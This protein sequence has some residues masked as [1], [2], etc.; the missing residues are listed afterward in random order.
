[1]ASHDNKYTHNFFQFKIMIVLSYI[2]FCKIYRRLPWKAWKRA[3]IKCF[4]RQNFQGVWFLIFVAWLFEICAIHDGL[5][6]SLQCFPVSLSSFLT[7][8]YTQFS[9][10]RAQIM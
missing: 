5:P 4:T 9:I 8:R 10:A 3:N 6:H 2:F 1:M 7:F